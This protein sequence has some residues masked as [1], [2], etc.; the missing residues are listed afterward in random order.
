MYNLYILSTDD[1]FNKIFIVYW[2][3]FLN[4]K[5]GCIKVLIFFTLLS[6]GL[7][8]KCFPKKVN[9]ILSS[10]NSNTEV[11]LRIAEN[12]SSKYWVHV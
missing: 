10:R 2:C 3:F 7:V 5:S 4:Y 6:L 8:A 9:F 12:T 1:D 11:S